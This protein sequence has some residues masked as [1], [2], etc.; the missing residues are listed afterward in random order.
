MYRALVIGTRVH[1]LATSHVLRAV[2]RLSLKL[3]FP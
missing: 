1:V 3:T 2:R